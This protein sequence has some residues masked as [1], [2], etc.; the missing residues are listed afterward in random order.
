[1]VRILHIGATEIDFHKPECEIY[2]LP[3]INK[4][5]GNILWGSTLIK[6]PGNKVNSSWKD[7]VSG[8]YQDKDSNYG[9]SFKLNRNTKILEIDNMDDYISVMKKYKRLKYPHGDDLCLDF[10]KISKDYD[11]FHLTEDAFW[12]LRMPMYKEFYDLKYSD[13]SA[14][15]AESWIVFNLDCINKGSILNHNNVFSK[16]R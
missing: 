4:P 3:S 6:L 1:M 7:Y 5:F 12:E 9:V 16:W 15:D 8:D 2:T 10:E 11:A 14:Y 13:F